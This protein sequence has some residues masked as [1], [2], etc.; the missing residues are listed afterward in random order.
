MD[1]AK[2]LLGQR[3]RQVRRAKNLTQSDLAE[4]IGFS[5]NYISQIETGIA[6]PTFETLVRIADG[7]EMPLKEL[8]DF[9]LLNEKDKH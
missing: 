8:C 7:L 3:I 2:K 9:D 4:K 5:V 1:K 6:S